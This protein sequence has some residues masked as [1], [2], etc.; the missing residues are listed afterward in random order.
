MEPYHKTTPKC[1][2]DAQ[3]FDHLSLNGEHSYNEG[4]QASLNALRMAKRII[5]GVGSQKVK[6]GLTS[7][8]TIIKQETKVKLITKFFGFWI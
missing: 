6:E 7:M 2:S 1:Q 8:R 3:R 4:A 5:M